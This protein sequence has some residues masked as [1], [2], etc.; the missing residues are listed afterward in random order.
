MSWPN[1]SHRQEYFSA[2]R[3]M[4]VVPLAI[5]LTVSFMSAI[6]LLGISAENYVHGT[7]ITLLYLGGFFGTPIA[8]YFYLPVFAQL[9]S[10]SVYEVITLDRTYLLVILELFRKIYVEI[11]SVPVSGETIR[12]RGTTGHQL[13]QLPTTVALHRSSVVRSIVG[14][15]SD[16]WPVREHERPVD[17]DDLHFLFHGGWNQGCP[18]HRRLSRIAHVRWNRLRPRHSG[19]RPRRR[20]V[21]R[22]GHRPTGRSNRLLR[23]RIRSLELDFDSGKLNPISSFRIDP[24]VRHTWWGLLIGGTT[25]FL[26]LYAVNQVQ[27]QRLLTAK[28]VSRQLR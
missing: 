14:P 28:C 19:R 20:L 9:N 24:T 11:I 7:Q 25:I 5:A 16:H 2:N 4:G 22:M 21:Q 12:D 1:V 23:V 10:M 8:L 3:T 27:V 13:R 6:T 17:R 15:R 26:S 18:H